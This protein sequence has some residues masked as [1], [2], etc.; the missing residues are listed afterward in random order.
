MMEDSFGR[1]LYSL[2]P[3]LP[4]QMNFSQ[5]NR[6]AGCG[7]MQ[8]GMGR[9][10][11]KC[12]QCFC[13]LCLFKRDPRI[14]KITSLPGYAWHKFKHF[15][16]CSEWQFSICFFHILQS[17]NEAPSLQP[18]CDTTSARLVFPTLNRGVITAFLWCSLTAL[19]GLG[20]WKAFLLP[21]SK[22]WKSKKTYILMIIK[23]N[24]LILHKF[25]T[26]NMSYRHLCKL[27]P[28]LDA[29]LSI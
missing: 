22:G 19:S 21:P 27:Q 25:D 28:L 7:K 16:S 12:V 1:I 13:F 23:Y 20:P 8:G 18:V 2:S 4:Q 15:A 14:S 11:T 6:T 10:G 26:W 5:A 9:A 17:W 3:S 29:I 24:F